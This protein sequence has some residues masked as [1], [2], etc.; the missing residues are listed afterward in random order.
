MRMDAILKLRVSA[1]LKC[2][3]RLI[4]SCFIGSSLR[5]KEILPLLPFLPEHQDTGA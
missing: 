4:R 5:N 1:H 2:D 3:L